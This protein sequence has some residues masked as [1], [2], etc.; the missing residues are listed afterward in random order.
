MMLVPLF[1]SCQKEL[2]KEESNTEISSV[3]SRVSN[4]NGSQQVDVYV[5]G[6]EFDGKNSFGMYWK[7]GNPILLTNCTDASSIVVVG[8]DVYVAGSDGGTAKYWK[9]GSPVILGAGYARSIAVSGNDVYVCGYTGNAFY[10][11]HACYWKNGDITFLP[12]NTRSDD[13]WD[14]YPVS[15]T[16]SKAYSIFISGSDVYIAGQE[17]VVRDGGSGISAVY[18]KNG[19]EVYLIK[20]S[21]AGSKDDAAN[22]IFVTGQDI[23]ACGALEAQY[24]KNGMSFYLPGSSGIT[25]MAN[26]IFVLGTDVYVAGTQKDGKF[27]QTYYSQQKRYV[28]KYWKNGQPVNLT[29]GTKDAYATSVSIMGTDLYAA[30]YEEK[31]AGVRN[32]I[33]KYWKNGKP[34]IL[35]AFSKNS[36]SRANSIFLV[37]K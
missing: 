5:A 28:A 34:V 8:N 29:D 26:S 21:F 6:N 9:N 2:T 11:Y 14:D 23:Y 7:N 36:T 18:W 33:A 37:K 22:S 3:T 25:T 27:Y 20:G 4:L 13:Y 30:G 15:S 19:D 10:G 24:W 16:D 35:G 31:Q 32:W 12:E 1:Y 17:T